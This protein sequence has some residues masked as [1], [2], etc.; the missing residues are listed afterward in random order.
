MQ[1]AGVSSTAV[2]VLASMPDRQVSAS[3]VSLKQQLIYLAAVLGHT[4]EFTDFPK[5]FQS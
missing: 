1:I 5:V 2:S 4:V 3:G